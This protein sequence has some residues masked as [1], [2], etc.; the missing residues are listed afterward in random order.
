MS[1]L[2]LNLP[3]P[4]AS[5]SHDPLEEQRLSPARL[6]LCSQHG[7]Q[8]VSNTVLQTKDSLG[9]SREVTKWLERYKCLIT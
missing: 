1:A 4:E 3:F 7:T 6:Q 9:P 8:G 5:A 2:G